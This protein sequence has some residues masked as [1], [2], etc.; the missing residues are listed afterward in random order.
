MPEYL[1]ISI[2]MVAVTIILA[3]SVVLTGVMATLV[4]HSVPQER[5]S[6]TYARVFESCVNRARGVDKEIISLCREVAQEVSLSQ[7]GR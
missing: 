7:L 4:L 1:I 6:D 3:M 5:Y 2:K